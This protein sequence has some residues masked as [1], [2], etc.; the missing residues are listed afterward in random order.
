MRR[1]AL[2]AL[3]LCAL[4]AAHADPQSN[5]STLSNAS[6]LVASGLA[7]GS[8]SLLAGASEVVIVSAEK[9]GDG[10][11]LVLA[12]ASEAARVTVNLSGKAVQGMALAVG[13]TVSVVAASTGY[14]LVCAGK[15]LAFV[16]NEAGKALL[17]HSK[18]G[19]R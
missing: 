19:S 7:I 10:V 18:A 2:P 12:G 17:H 5:A 1:F 8:L 14:V 3:L 6:E 13:T 9:V 11:I 15:V 16:P 4:G